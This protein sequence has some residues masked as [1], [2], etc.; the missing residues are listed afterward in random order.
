MIMS[1]EKSAERGVDLVR[2]I[3]AFAQGVGGVQQVVE[4][5]HLLDET[6]SVVRES[7]PKN[8]SLTDCVPESSGR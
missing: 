2:Q 4:V 6:M 8:I 5:K 3:L 1:L 7:F